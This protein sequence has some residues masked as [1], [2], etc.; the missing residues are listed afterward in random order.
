MNENQVLII[1][2]S[3]KVVHQSACSFAVVVKIHSEVEQMQGGG[4]IVMAVKKSI[5]IGFLYS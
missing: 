3:A 5:G 4:I 2:N 1:E